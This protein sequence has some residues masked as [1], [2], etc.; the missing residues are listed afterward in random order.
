MLYYGLKM[1]VVRFATALQLHFGKD[2]QLTTITRT[3]RSEVCSV[4][5][6]IDTLSVAIVE[7]EAVSCSLRLTN[8]WSKTTPATVSRRR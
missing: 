8:I 6:V 4:S 7:K 5:I 3:G 1:D 2:L